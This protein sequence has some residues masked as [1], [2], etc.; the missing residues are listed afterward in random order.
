MSARRVVDTDDVAGEKDT[1]R[2]SHIVSQFSMSLPSD[3]G[4]AVPPTAGEEPGSSEVSSC[5]LWK[6]GGLWCCLSELSGAVGRSL[7]IVVGHDFKAAVASIVVQKGSFYVDCDAD[8][9]ID[10]RVR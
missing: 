9:D 8:K 6:R 3:V 2:C 4:G 1:G 7:E 10:E 5:K